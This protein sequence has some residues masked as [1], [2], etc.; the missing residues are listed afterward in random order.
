MGILIGYW[1]LHTSRGEFCCWRTT[2]PH[3]QYVDWPYTRSKTKCWGRSN[4]QFL[5]NF[6]N[7]KKKFVVNQLASTTIFTNIFHIAKKQKEKK[8]Y[9]CHIVLQKLLGSRWKFLDVYYYRN[10][11]GYEQF[12]LWKFNFR[13][14]VAH[15]LAAVTISPNIYNFEHIDKR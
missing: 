9:Q 7:D 3:L 11:S 12:L 13:N 10:C 15:Q 8:V 5:Y 14:I 2:C 4:L 1:L 6:P